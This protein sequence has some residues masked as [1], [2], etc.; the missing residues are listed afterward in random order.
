[1]LRTA[2]SLVAPSALLLLASACADS[3]PAGPASQYTLNLVPVVSNNQTAAFADLERLD[4]VFTGTDG[5]EQ[6]VALDL[7][8]AG[9]SARAEGLPEL[10]ETTIT[11]EGYR[12]GAVVLWG[13]TEPLSA[14]SGEVDARVFVAETQTIAYLGALSEGLYRPAAAALGDGRFLLAGGLVPGRAGNKAVDTFYTLSLAPPGELMAFE[15]IGTLPEYYSGGGEAQTRRAYATYTPLLQ[16]GPDQGHV[17]IVGGC[18]GD[19]V[20]AS[21]TISPS[22]T[23]YDPA[24][25]EWLSQPDSAALESPRAGHVALENVQGNVVVFGGFGYVSAQNAYS[26]V[27]TAEMYDRAAGEFKRVGELGAGSVG[28][29]I[30]DIGVDGT[31]ICGGADIGVGESSGWAAVASCARVSLDGTAASDRAALPEPRA[32]HGMVA[33]SDGRVLVA[34]GTDVTGG[35]IGA[36]DAVADA[37]IYDPAADTWTAT[38]DMG[39]ARAG[40]RLAL[41]PDGTVLVVGGAQSYDPFAPP[42]DPLSCL[43]RFDPAAGTFTVLGG[44]TTESNVGGLPSAAFEPEVVVDPV[45]GAL[46]VGGLGADGQPQ[47][48]V[49]VFVPAR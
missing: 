14:S 7:P 19:P 21:M 16:T 3:A 35:G 45:R 17:L 46:I 18:A 23:L 22:F 33:L 20:D 47:T 15:A 13:R 37:W 29:G 42:E 44:C 34:G 8:D 2:R 32:A 10:D 38:G 43:E 40:H 49:S 25:D 41:L 5:S 26:W 6:R 31:L 36:G 30:A 24:T 9:E 11:V 28:A 12:G 39:I 27:T 48:A 4:L 1:M